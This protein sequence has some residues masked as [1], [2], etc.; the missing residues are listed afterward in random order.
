MAAAAGAAPAA[1]SVDA[2]VSVSP[3]GRTLFRVRKTAAKMLVKRC[4]AAHVRAA[5]AAAAAAHH[6]HPRPSCPHAPRLRS[7]Y[8]V[9]EKDL[10]MTLSAFVDEF[11]A[12]PS[13]DAAVLGGSKSGDASDLIRVVFP[14]GDI[15]VK[16]CQEIARMIQS[17]GARR[18]VI[19]VNGKFTNFAK[20]A[21]LDLAPVAALEHFREEELL[22]DITE[23]EL[24]PEHIVL[25][26]AEKAA[27]LAR[28]KLRD[29][30]LPRMQAAD[31]VA[32][33]LGVARG[34][35][36]KITRPSETAGR[37]VTYRIVV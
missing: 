15:S 8:T 25:T 7:G 1:V 4:V 36:I 17:Q 3:A 28:Y 21:L 37:Y 31:P 18:G 35:V 2:D 20:Q 11:G 32:R 6:A 33:F 10:N 30:Q 27:L 5:V 26:D 24:V 12:T 23:H 29:S 16:K 19:V 9:S 22:I 14:E 13:R 34:Q